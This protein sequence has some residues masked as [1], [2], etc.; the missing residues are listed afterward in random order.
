MSTCRKKG[1]GQALPDLLG[2]QVSLMF[3]SV[4]SSLPHVRAGKL[5]AL[6]VSTLKRLPTL[7]ELATIAESGLPGFEVTVW[8]GVLA[9]SGTPRDIVARINSILVAALRS[10]DLK[11]RLSGR[12]PKRSATRPNEFETQIRSDLVKWAKVIRDSGAKLD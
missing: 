8:Y 3:G 5:R 1:G 12:A 10:A 9:P 6:G 11:Q 7:P 4:T 2:G